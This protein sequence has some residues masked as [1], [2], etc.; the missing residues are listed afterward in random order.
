MACH[1]MITAW[2]QNCDI[3]SYQMKEDQFL[4]FLFRTSLCLEVQHNMKMEVES[5]YFVKT[6]F[7]GEYSLWWCSNAYSKKEKR[8]VLCIQTAVGIAKWRQE[9]S[10]FECMYDLLRNEN[11]LEK[12][13]PICSNV[14]KNMVMLC[15]I[16]GT[17]W[18]PQTSKPIDL[19]S[20]IYL[21]S[22]FCF[23]VMFKIGFYNYCFRTSTFWGV[24]YKITNEDMLR[25]IDF[26]CSLPIFQKCSPNRNDDWYPL[27]IIDD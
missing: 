23:T 8:F 12:I 20:N 14:A 11:I 25:I 1:K 15:K 2:V 5:K 7:M 21:I 3:S 13:F 27:M 10:V 19:E 18:S 26:Y 16:L 9:L 17:I 24:E 4:N 6:I 22:K